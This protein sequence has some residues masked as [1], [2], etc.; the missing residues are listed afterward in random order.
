LPAGTFWIDASGPAQQTNG[1]AIRLYN[2]T[3]G[4]VQD[5]G[6]SELSWGNGSTQPHATRSTLRALVTVASPTT[7]RIDHFAASANFGGGVVSSGQSEIYT[8]V[9]IT[10]IA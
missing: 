6:T 10:Q 2:V 9:K 4:A 3:A 7:F 5:I 1:H 8:E